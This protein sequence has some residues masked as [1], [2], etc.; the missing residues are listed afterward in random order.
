[1]RRAGPVALLTSGTSG[2]DGGGSAP[3][4][5]GPVEGDVGRAVLPVIL[6]LAAVLPLAAGCATGFVAGCRMWRGR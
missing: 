5:G 6:L 3:A 2:P 4:G 1:M